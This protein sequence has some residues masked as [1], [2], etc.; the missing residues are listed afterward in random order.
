M[1]N[2]RE[3]P[4]TGYGHTC[5]AHF[6]LNLISPFRT[7]VRVRSIAWY[8]RVVLLNSNVAVSSVPPLHAPIVAQTQS[9]GSHGT[10]SCTEARDASANE[11][12]RRLV[13]HLAAG[14][15]GKGPRRRRRRLKLGLETVNRAAVS[16]RVFGC[17][18][19]Q[20]CF[21]SWLLATAVEATAS[22]RLRRVS[23]RVASAALV[24]RATQRC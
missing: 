3:I 15:L 8:D 22:S 21:G 7:S 16:D 9:T 23:Y 12:Q 10:H 4:K 24:Q 19:C 5:T 17:S 11:A 1:F 6:L 13:A 18:C 20:R 14:G 2:T